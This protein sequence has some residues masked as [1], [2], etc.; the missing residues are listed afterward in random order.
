MVC[1]Y[2]LSSFLDILISNEWFG[3]YAYSF[4]KVIILKNFKNY[5]AMQLLECINKILFLMFLLTIS[6]HSSLLHFSITWLVVS[7]DAANTAIWNIALFETHELISSCMATSFK[8][9]ASLHLFY[10]GSICLYV[11]HMQNYWLKD[12]K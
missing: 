7:H 1:C 9:A 8:L 3:K 4:T 12:R 2:D 10:I 6:T 5:F 11:L